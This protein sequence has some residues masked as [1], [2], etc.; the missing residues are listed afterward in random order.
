MEIILQRFPGLGKKVIS[1][2]DD[3]SL[4]VSKKVNKTWRNFIDQEKTIWIRC[5]QKYVKNIDELQDWKKSVS[6]TRK[7]S[8]QNALLP[9]RK[10]PN[11]HCVLM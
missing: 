3:K 1:Q 6:K 4:V 7:L 8:R 11:S 2:L 5:I 10:H 9:S